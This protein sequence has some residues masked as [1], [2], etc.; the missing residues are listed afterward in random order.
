MT[1]VTFH[2]EHPPLQD[3]P[4]LIAFYAGPGTGKSTTAAEVFAHLKRMGYN[5]E[6]VHEVAKD[7]TWEKRHKALAYQ[8]Y[9][10]V[11]QMWAWDRLRGEVDVIVT[12]TSTLLGLIHGKKL[13]PAFKT[14]LIDDYKRRRTLNIFLQRDPKRAYNPKGRRES[15]ES[16]KAVDNRVWAMLHEQ[17]IHHHVVQ[18]G[19]TA[20]LKIVS[21]A[22]DRLSFMGVK[23]NGN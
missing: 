15:E 13:T 2:E 11:K 3:G 8:P 4:L 1:I 6:Y 19:A 21:K 17:K 20:T 9:V 23:L 10:A 12:D 5:A 16:A 18:M 22:H 7:F 14:W